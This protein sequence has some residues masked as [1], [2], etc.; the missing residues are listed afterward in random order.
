MVTH[1][2]NE[3]PIDLP[4]DTEAA[5]MILDAVLTKGYTFRQF[6]KLTDGQIEAVYAM[7]YQSFNLRQYQRAETLFQWLMSLD[8]VD[9]RYKIGLGAVRQKQG[10][11]EAAI[12]CYSAA[13]MTDFY[14]PLPALR[15]AE[16]HIQLGD[17]EK[18]RSAALFAIRACGDK[19]EHEPWKIRA[20]LILRGIEA[21]RAKRQREQG[22]VA[23]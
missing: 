16:C 4:A 20:E 17:Q 11:Y 15:S 21:R 12:R 13:L 9:S 14:N 22:S 5:E 6:T 8:H 10:N 18:A 3:T 1:T 23:E 7:A 2:L 19:L